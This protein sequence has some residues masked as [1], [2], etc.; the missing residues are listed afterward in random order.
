[1][2]EPLSKQLL[3]KQIRAS[4]L[5]FFL[6]AQVSVAQTLAP[7]SVRPLEGPLVTGVAWL[8]GTHVLLAGAA[9]V[10]KFSLDDATSSGVIASVALPDGIPYPLAV[11]SDGRTVVASNGFE[12][13]QFAWNAAKGQRL[14]ARSSMS[15]LVID[16]AVSRDRLDIL[17][18]PV[19]GAGANNPD[20]VAV[21]RGGV[22]YRFNEFKPLHR[23]TSGPESVAIF[24]ESLPMYGG[25]LAVEKNGTLDV[26]TA[27]EP[28]V[29]QYS[30]DGV[31]LRRVG[32]RLG[33]LVMHRMH[34]INVTYSTDTVSRYTKVINQQ[35]TID[36]LITTPE[37]PAIVVRLVKDNVVGW[38]LWY[39]NDERLEKRVKLG[40]SRLGPFGHLSC[41]A[42]EA[43]LACV[44][45]APVSASAAAL[46]NQSS[47]P[48][49]LVQFKLPA[50]HARPEQ[51]ASKGK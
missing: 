19:D 34:D 26:I 25:A 6:G 8:D 2:G 32:A 15:P 28:G 42:R 41:D 43:D 13:T 40:I 29:F 18:W 10:R 3:S 1:M 49:F 27:A 24:N 7:V 5:L 45:Q 14:F 48:G 30:P 11:V 44:Y 12:R 39:P 36:D 22:N 47:A 23:I 50:S 17:A 16:L 51:R 4:F 33:E 46:P 9:G 21:W 31:L 37:G 20:G 38:E 35:P